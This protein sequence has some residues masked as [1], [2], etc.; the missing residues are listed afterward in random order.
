MDLPWTLK[1]WLE[2]WTQ[3]SRYEMSTSKKETFL[4]RISTLSSTWKNSLTI[5]SEFLMWILETSYGMFFKRLSPSIFILRRFSL[6]STLSQE[7]ST[8]P[9]LAMFQLHSVWPT[10]RDM[11]SLK[12]TSSTRLSRETTFFQILWTSSS[13]LLIKISQWKTTS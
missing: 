1:T 4:L 3:V 9:S 6:T 11:W 7:D 8:L 13:L 5:L 10:S 2:S 12:T